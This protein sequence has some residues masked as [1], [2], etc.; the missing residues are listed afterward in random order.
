MKHNVIE[1][2]C[3]LVVSARKIWQIRGDTWT[4]D[5]GAVRI[6]KAKPALRA[7]EV[8]IRLNVELP[9]AL[10][11]QPDLVAKIE[12]PAERVPFVIAPEV[13]ENIAEQI[14]AQTGFTVRL[15]VAAPG[16]KS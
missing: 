4:G 1:F 2:S 12:V 6:T 9:I 16:D 10:F 15:D 13:Q 7:N 3:H 14:R 11:R 5:A 8:A